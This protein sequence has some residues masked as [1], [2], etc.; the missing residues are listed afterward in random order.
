MPRVRKRPAK[1]AGKGQAD[2]LVGQSW[3][4]WK[5]HLHETGPTWLFCLTCLSHLLC[6]R[7]S[8]TLQLK[9]GNF[10][11]AGG[12]V[13]V[14]AMKRG[15]E[16]RKP[17]SQAAHKLIQHWVSGNGMTVQR[18]RRC[19]SRGLITFADTWAWPVEQDDFLFPST[20]KDAA[21]KNM[22]KAGE[23]S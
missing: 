11:L 14:G 22:N 13:V 23:V 9:R 12:W 3:K 19:G 10:D 15:A 17:L 6:C 18:T 5:A 20:R 1:K 7:V 4:A 8:E 2:S 16:L 21:K